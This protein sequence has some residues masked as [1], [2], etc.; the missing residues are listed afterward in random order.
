MIDQHRRKM[1]QDE[2]LSIEKLCVGIL[3][4]RDR[5]AMYTLYDAKDLTKS[6]LG[7]FIKDLPPDRS[8]FSGAYFEKIIKMSFTN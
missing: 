3:A 5:I 1:D 8:P 4:A 6:I 2:E 7:S